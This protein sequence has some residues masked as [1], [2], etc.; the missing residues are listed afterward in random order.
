[1]MDTPDGTPSNVAGSGVEPAKVADTLADTEASPRIRL[2][3]LAFAYACEPGRG[4]EP[5][6]GWAWSRMLAHLGETWVITRRDYQAS[7]EDALP[8]LPERDNLTFVYVDL[9]FAPKD[10]ITHH[11]EDARAWQRGVRGLRLYYLLWQIAALIEARRLQR[12]THFDVV[13]HLTWANAWYGSLAALAGRPFVY[14]PVGGCVD[15]AWRLLP[16]LGLSGAAYEIGRVIARG[17]ARYL[18]PLARLSWHHADLILAQ[19]AETRDW[20]PAAH[21]GKTRLF[22]NAVIGEELKAS[23]VQPSR[24]G[25]PCVVY[26]G[27]LAPWKGVFL[28][29][30]VMTLLPDWRLVVCGAGKDEARLR[31]LARRLG[32][33]ERIEWLGWISRQKVLK[34][35]A[36]ADV[37]LF[38]SL[39]D[40]APWVVAEARAL[41]IPIVCL[42]RG[43][44]RVL[45]GPTGI[46]VDDSGGVR[47]ITRRLAD[48]MLTCLDRGRA[49]YMDWQADDLK[50]AGRADALMELLSAGLLVSDA[51][52]AALGSD[53]ARRGDASG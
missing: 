21:R 50:L 7:I 10:V 42:A 12:S 2:R 20:F 49:D 31:R 40:D 32:V 33:D 39:H 26:A 34:R 43:G 36:E 19:N 17:A 28:C 4:S 9:P 11:P 35:L 25:P 29:L 8:S 45:A 18:N 14:G 15:P 47:A 16:Q 52:D 41:G 13:W 46:C 6:A 22:P 53:Q 24:S 23:D 37:F 38:P 30:H 3:I 48:G 5:G 27:R 51:D 1:M 44:P